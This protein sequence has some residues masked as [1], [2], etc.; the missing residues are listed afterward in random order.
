MIQLMDYNI[1]I[2]CLQN[3]IDNGYKVDCC[4]TYY[5]YK[6]IKKWTNDNEHCPHCRKKIKNNLYNI[7]EN[8]IQS[9]NIENNNIIESQY[10]FITV[11]LTILFI[12]FEIIII[13]TA[14]YFV[15]FYLINKIII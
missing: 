2:I 8:I 4:N 5:H 9:N 14:V 7:P 1:C 11:C 15:I 3:I 12:F 6:C 13:I 10:N